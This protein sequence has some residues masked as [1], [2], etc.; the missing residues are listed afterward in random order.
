MALDISGNR[1]I[2]H[3]T[4]ED[5]RAAV[6]EIDCAGDG[7]L[8]LD[9]EEMTYLQCSRTPDAGFIVECQVESID[10]HFRATNEHIDAKTVLEMFISY[11]RGADNWRDAVDWEILPL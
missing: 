4:E 9:I 2:E 6:N 5:L 1:M 3:P 11:A 10:Q 8:I 7:F